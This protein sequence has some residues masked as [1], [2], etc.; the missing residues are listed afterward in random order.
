MMVKNKVI[1]VILVL[2]TS[3]VFVSA[4][5]NIEEYS[6]S[7]VLK[8]A[9]T[10]KEVN[11][12]LMNL[13]IKNE[14]TSEERTISSFLKKSSFSLTLEKGNYKIKFMID[15][16]TTNGKDY[17]AIYGV[18][19]DKNVKEEVIL[20]PVG[21]I[22][23]SVLDNLNNLVPKTSLKI[24]CDKDYGELGEI[25]SDKF[26]SFKS[27]YLPVGEC[28]ITAKFNSA[29]GSDKVVIEQ[30][31][32]KDIAI[33]LDKSAIGGSSSFLFYGIIFVL[34]IVLFFFSRKFLKKRR[35]SKKEE[36]D[37]KP[38][39]TKK[40]AKESR[41]QEDLMKTLNDREKKVVRH[42]LDND[43]KSTQAKIRHEVGIPKTSLI[44]VFTSLENKKILSVE[45]FGKL[46]KIKLTAWFLEKE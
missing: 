3:V 23:G 12:V 15:D 16:I 43:N 40:E 4:Q 22:Q 46:K 34:L 19:L 36:M 11:N 18:N 20:L 24:E 29:V 27:L 7:I 31:K 37:V 33:K 14:D 25:T 42:L 38:V 32:T 13:V 45:K 10:G 35:G 9:V 39:E 2:F 26:G 41:R 17:Y 21:S 5:N 1:L 6:L 30:G 8:D 44:R 28:K